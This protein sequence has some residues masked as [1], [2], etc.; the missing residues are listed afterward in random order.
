MHESMSW[1]GTLVAT[2]PITTSVFTVNTKI[3]ALLYHD[4]ENVVLSQ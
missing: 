4:N 1:T 2:S 3:G